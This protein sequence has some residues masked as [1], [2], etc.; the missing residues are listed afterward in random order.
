MRRH[1]TLLELLEERENMKPKEVSFVNLNIDYG[2]L[3]SNGV[4]AI[5]ALKMV[6][7]AYKEDRKA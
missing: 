7:K 3:R 4:S 6:G 1:R 5:T 2:F